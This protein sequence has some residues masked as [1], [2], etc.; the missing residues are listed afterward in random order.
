[1]SL[2]SPEGSIP[3]LT[4]VDTAID[5]SFNVDKPVSAAG[6]AQGLA[7]CFGEGLVVLGEAADLSTQIIDLEAEEF[8]MN[9]PGLD[10]RQLALNIM[11]WLSGPLE[12]P[13]GRPQEG[14]ISLENEP[15]S[16]VPLLLPLMAL[17]IEE[18]EKKR[19]P[20]RSFLVGVAGGVGLGAVEPGSFHGV[21]R[22][23]TPADHHEFLRVNVSANCDGDVVGVEAADRLFEVAL[24]SWKFVSLDSCAE[25]GVGAT[26]FATSTGTS[27]VR[28]LGSFGS[29]F[30]G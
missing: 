14:R 22:Q 9:V 6:R 4:P 11:D 27:N 10:N 2:K 15:L 19:H 26:A 20:A 17:G 5:L 7:L 12:P 18:S 21:G 1:M 28:L 16:L 24:T 30:L 29:S 23:I 3:L 25:A 8:G 13:R